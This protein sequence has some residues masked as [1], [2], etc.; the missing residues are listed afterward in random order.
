MITKTKAFLS[1]PSVQIFVLLVLAGAANGSVHVLADEYRAG[2]E[3]SLTFVIVHVMAVAS[4]ILFM[5]QCDLI[6]RQLKAL[7]D[8][9]VEYKKWKARR[10]QSLD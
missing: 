10:E 3:W 6:E 9:S 8:I 5:M 7:R 4:F 1:R 2:A